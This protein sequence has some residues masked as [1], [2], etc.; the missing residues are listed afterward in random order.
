[1]G[2]ISETVRYNQQSQSQDGGSHTAVHSSNLSKDTDAEAYT[3]TDNGQ[4]NYQT[5]K[6]PNYG[7]IL[8]NYQ[9]T[10]LLNYR[11]KLQNYRIAK[12]PKYQ[13][14]KQPDYQT[15]KLPNNQT[16]ELY[17]QT[18]KQQDCQI[19]KVVSDVC[20]FAGAFDPCR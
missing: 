18:T 3:D 5:T 13:T 6:I 2:A 9:I 16:T 7:T 8:P 10:K 15:T 19:N 14:T 20:V 12:L 1:M 17:Y 4:L 11:T